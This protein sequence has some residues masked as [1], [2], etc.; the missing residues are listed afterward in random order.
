MKYDLT[1]KKVLI[2]G[3][4]SG[5]GKAMAAML[6]KKGAKVLITGRDEAKLKQ[7]AEQLNVAF[8]RA[9]VAKD[10]E[11]EQ[12]YS[13]VDE[14]LGGL[15]VLIN[16][17]GIGSSLWPEVDEL[18]RENIR[19]VHEVNV[20]GAAVVAAHAA[21]IFKTQKSGAIVNIA[22]TAAM[23]GYKRGS[24]YTSSK[25]ALRAF[26]QCW[27]AELRPYNVRVIGVNPSE[28]PTAFNQPERE[29][30]PDD[31]KKLSSDEIAHAVVS[32]LEMDTRGF[33]P[34]LTVWATNP[35]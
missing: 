10:E 22:S 4:S 3:G 18:T 29:E 24:V 2:T 35:F 11:I 31:P 16:N 34:E 26:T 12:M 23:K 17:A 7:V 1:G 27:Q 6:Q 21:K 5:L 14:E 19:E 25:F 32:A 30:R 15:D 20:L 28:V 9:D 8:C 13:K 33:I